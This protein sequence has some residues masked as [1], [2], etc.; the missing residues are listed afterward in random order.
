[1]RDRGVY[2][3]PELVNVLQSSTR[4]PGSSR[5]DELTPHAKLEKE[6][7]ATV[8]RTVYAASPHFPHRLHALP[9]LFCASTSCTLT[10]FLALPP[11]F[12]SYDCILHSLYSTHALVFRLNND[13]D[14]Q[15]LIARPE[16]LGLGLR[17]RRLHPTHEAQRYVTLWFYNRLNTYWNNF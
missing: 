14:T 5:I 2:G 16:L 1:M 9:K 10:S 11:Q 13:S 6:R 8:T 7:A 15:K 3:V 4:G 17:V 12:G